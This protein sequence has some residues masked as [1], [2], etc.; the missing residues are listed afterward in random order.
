MEKFYSHIKLRS[1]SK[2]HHSFF[3]S[4][5]VQGSG[6][7]Y[8]LSCVGDSFSKCCDTIFNVGYLIT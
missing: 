4:Y 6:L 2:L 8:I 7:V 5:V 3:E 1:Y